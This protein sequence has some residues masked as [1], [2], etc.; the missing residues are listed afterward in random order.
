MVGGAL[1]VLAKGTEGLA[2]RLALVAVP[3]VLVHLA[4]RR[5]LKDRLQPL[6]DDLERA[7]RDLSTPGPSANDMADRPHDA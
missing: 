4:N 1:I 2:A 7:V 3:G 5:G 6:R